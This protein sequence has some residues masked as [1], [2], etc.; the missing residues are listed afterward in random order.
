MQI[1]RTSCWNEALSHA[2]AS[3]EN[4]NICTQDVHL[5]LFIHKHGDCFYFTRT[6]TRTHTIR[7]S[8]RKEHIDLINLGVHTCICPLALQQ[9]NILHVF[10][11]RTMKRNALANIQCNKSSPPSANNTSPSLHDSVLFFSPLLF[12]SSSLCPIL[13]SLHYFLFR[14]ASPPNQIRKRI[15][16]FLNGLKNNPMSGLNELYITITK[17]IIFPSKH[18]TSGRRS[19]HVCTSVCQTSKTGSISEPN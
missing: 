14:T 11:I 17:R 2:Q 10:L 18:A 15:M 3:W 8:I 12:P 6:R 13:L 19:D 5:F 7:K 4:L 16:L 1:V 9:H